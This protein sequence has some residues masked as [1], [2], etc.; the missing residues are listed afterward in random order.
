MT[1]TADLAAVAARP[2]KVRIG[3]GLGVGNTLRGPEQFAEVVDDLERLGFD[4]LWMSDRTTGAALDPLA[5]LA[6]AAGRTS[7][8]KLGTNVVVLPGRDPFSIAR[9]VAAIDR[10]SGGRMLPAFGLGSPSRADRPPFAVERGTR[11]ARFEERLAVLRE[12]WTDG[13]AP[14]PEPGGTP[15][16]LD[17]R[18]TRPPEIWFGGRSPAALERTGRLAD[19]WLGSFQ[20]PE[21]TAAAR[22]AVEAAAARAGRTIDDDHFGTTI[23]YARERRTELGELVVRALSDSYVPELS[24][25]C[26]TDELT[27]AVRAHV[28]GGVSKF[29]VVPSDVPDDWTVELEW[30][31]SVTAPIET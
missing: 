4:S 21:E 28:A 22:R 13:E 26:G 31:R 29:V 24:L 3:V 30:L 20:V 16:R 5:A 23:F 11:A 10:L 19:G 27:A 6:F 1:E 25:P 18:P 17:P 14:H 8:L 2:P 7:R 15:Y 12:L 9:Q